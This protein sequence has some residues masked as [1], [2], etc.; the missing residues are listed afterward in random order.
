MR[1]DFGNGAITH[2]LNKIFG[3]KLSQDF[4]DRCTAVK[5]PASAGRGNS[6]QF[7]GGVLQRREK[8]LKKHILCCSHHGT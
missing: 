8:G 5:M 6:Q 4:R 2:F 3:R 1:L 7:Y